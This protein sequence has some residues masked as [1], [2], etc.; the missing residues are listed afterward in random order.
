M[1]EYLKDNN[2]KRTK[3]AIKRGCPGPKIYDVDEALTIITL[4]SQWWNQPYDKPRPSDGLCDAITPE[5][6]KGELEDAVEE[7]HNKN[8]L[9]VGHYPI[10]SLGHYG[11]YF[12]VG[13]QF[14]PFPIA[15]SFRTAFH[16]N[17]GGKKDISNEHLNEFVESM[18][19]LLFFHS[20]L[21][22]AS[23]HEK[24]QQIIR[25]GK[26]FLLNSGAPAK[27][28]YATQDDNTFM[29]V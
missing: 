3:W 21:I 10:H 22:Y 12:S 8:I 27:A 23:G 5:N 11:G 16:S 7:N 19:N 29:K 1:S 6:L 25:R 2:Y 20:N 15:G 13:D 18:N 24:N 14:K 9:I 28:D 4:N 17:I 26:N